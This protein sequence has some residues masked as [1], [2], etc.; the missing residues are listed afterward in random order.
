MRKIG[1]VLAIGVM[2]GTSIGCYRLLLGG[3]FAAQAAAPIS[4]QQEI[5]I[6]QAGVEQILAKP[7]NRLYREP[8]VNAYVSEVG[9][10]MARQTGRANLPWQFFILESPQKNAF[11]LPGG[12][13]FVTT[14]ILRS[15][16]NR[17]Q[18]AGVL[19][20]EAGHIGA[21]HGIAELK[22]ALLARGVLISALGDTPMAGQIAGRLAA[23]LVLRGY[24]RQAEFE[25]DELGATYSS[26][27]NYDPRQLEIFL[28]DL[29]KS[30]E[31]PAWLSPLETH[32]PIKE[33]IERLENFIQKKN[34]GGSRIEAIPFKADMAPLGKND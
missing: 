20:H 2:L 15:M 6:G 10:E 30:G 33:R 27:A 32:P 1:L 29:G 4:D 24:G 13:I 3:L 28:S 16:D 17:A 5:A 14:G 18:L 21:R 31:S 11:S 26:K 9:G 12:K 22:R 7:E 23:E 8:R 19:G 34:L 25:A